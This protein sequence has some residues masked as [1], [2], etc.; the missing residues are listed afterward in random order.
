MTIYDH[1]PLL[2]KDLFVKVH[3]HFTI[4]INML[5]IPP[6][7]TQTESLPIQ[8]E[9]GEQLAVPLQQWAFST[10]VTFTSIGIYLRLQPG[11]QVTAQSSTYLLSHGISTDMR[12]AMIS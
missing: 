5:V 6:F 3:I 2:V 7:P 1:R 10:T 11:L 4:V 8:T 9:I 12:S